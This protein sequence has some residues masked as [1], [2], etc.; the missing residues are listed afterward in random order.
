[1][2][3]FVLVLMTCATAFAA[4]CHGQCSFPQS[5]ASGALTYI[6]QPTVTDGKL[7]IRVNVEFQ[8]GRKG[9][10]DLELPSE[11]AGQ[12]HLES[13]V[14]NLRAVSSNTVILDTPRR[15]I[16]TLRFSPNHVV[17]LSYD[18]EKD[19]SG[20]FE[21]PKQFRV[22]LEPEFFEF[23]T[24]N[25]LV[26]PKL[27]RT[28]V[29]TVHFDWTGLPADWRLATSFGIE[30]RCQSFSGL[31]HKVNDALFA[32]GDFRLH[33]ITVAGQLLVV[34]IRDKWPFA[35]DE[36]VE[37]IQK[38]VAA[39]RN[40]WHDNN[41]P[42]YL[43]TIKPFDAQKG[44]TDGSAFTNAFWLYL[45]RSQDFSYGVQ[46]LLAHESFHAWNPHKMGPIPEPGESVHWFTE[47][48]TVYYSDLL[49]VRADLLSVPEYV[50]RL[51]RR[52]Y[53]YASSPVKNLS[54][55]EMVARYHEDGSLS[56]LP[57]IRGAV[58]ALWLDAQIRKESKH[59]F[60]LD[61]VMHGLVRDT[62]KDPRRPL[63][64]QRV[65]RAAAKYLNVEAVQILSR[66]I[67]K[68]ETIPIP[69]FPLSSCAR[70]TV[71]QIP[72]FDL[73]FDREILLAKNRV[74]G[75]N[76]ESEAFKAGLRDGQ[77]V[78][79]MSIY[80][81]DVSKPVRLKIRPA[82]GQQTIEYFPRGKTIPVPQYHIDEKAWTSTPE[83]CAFARN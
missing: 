33:R 80:W 4:R 61:T 5:S 50:E 32:G 69:D 28:D 38:I 73:G 26:H 62:S 21:Y 70:L 83:E 71:D 63:T 15:N 34:A 79:G 14:T 7:I 35:D 48:F 59:R 16:K 51:N 3:L 64:T 37:R 74:S 29:V 58:I 40:F 78:V 36:A 25:A 67:G 12:S 24:Q 68:G 47:G 6:F 39:E 19:W 2:T 23:N 81:N 27:N 41:F 17:T 22:V 54:N 82:D 8:G 65:L 44:S 31:W 1:M 53:D 18:L 9:T 77:E 49:L 43:I 75:V 20:A 46:Y 66:F 56:Q 11:W 30:D 52:I 42:Y 55:Q 45:L 13:E 57:Y 72:S 60:S 76:P 10:A